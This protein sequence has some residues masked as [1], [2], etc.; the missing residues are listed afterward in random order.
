MTIS[1][2]LAS[3]TTVV[4]AV[5]FFLIVLLGVC[6]LITIPINRSIGRGKWWGLMLALVPLMGGAFILFFLL[7]VRGGAPQFF[8]VAAALPLL[9]GIRAIQL[10]RRPRES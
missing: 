4:A 8:Y 5:F 1:P 3:D 6:S 7:T 2:I 10:W 9:V